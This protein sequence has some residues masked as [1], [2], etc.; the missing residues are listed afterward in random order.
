MATKHQEMQRIIRQYKEETG[1]TEIN[2]KDVA[3]YAVSKGWPLPAPTDPVDRL[4]KEFSQAAR[5]EIRYD[6]NTK[7]P[8]RANHAITIAQG[9]DQLHL[10][11]DIDEAKRVQMLMSLIKRRE[12]MIGDGLQLTFDADHW[13]SI[14]QDEEPI[15]LPMDLTPDIEW[16]G[17]APEEDEKA[18]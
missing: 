4:A 13:N 7:R 3:R 2:M 9:Q 15:L 6:Q 12:Q 16:R 17:N 8:Y 14:H 5:E 10:W 11:I 1:K 18:S